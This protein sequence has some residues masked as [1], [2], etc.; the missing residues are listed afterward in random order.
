[1][2]SNEMVRFSVVNSDK[3]LKAID[4]ESVEAFV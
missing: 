3:G 2:E 4:V 1:L